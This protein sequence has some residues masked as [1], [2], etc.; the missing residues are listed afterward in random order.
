ML[1]MLKRLFSFQGLLTVEVW[2]DDGFE[3]FNNINDNFT[4][5]LSNP[6]N[7]FN[8]SISL[9]VQGHHKVGNLTLS[10][11]NLT[12]DPTQYAVQWNVQ[13]PALLHKLTLAT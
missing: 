9:T 10:Y 3:P 12:T 2:E 1:I 8:S 11:G 13:H 5:P 6:L 7:K 4:F